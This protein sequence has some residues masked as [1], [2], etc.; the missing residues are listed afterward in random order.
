VVWNQLGDSARLG[1]TVL[2]QAIGDSCSKYQDIRVHESL[3]VTRSAIALQTGALPLLLI[4]EL[5]LLYRKLKPQHLVLQLSY[6]GGEV[7][8]IRSVCI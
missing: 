7:D 8:I 2:H 1:T 3:A 5:L 4:R 6:Y